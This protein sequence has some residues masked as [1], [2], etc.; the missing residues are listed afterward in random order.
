MSECPSHATKRRCEGETGAAA[1][2]AGMRR[3]RMRW[4][5]TGAACQ[6]HLTGPS[7]EGSSVLQLAR[8]RRRWLVAT[9][10][11]VAAVGSFLAWG[12]IGLG[13]GPI[14][15]PTAESGTYSW[16]ESRTEP[17]VYVLP[18]GNHGQGAAI[19]DT[20]VVTGRQG[21]APPVLLRAFAGRMSGY[22]C[23]AL[24]PFSGPRPVWAGCVQPRLDRVRGAAI[25]PGTYLF[26]GRIH[27]HEPALVLELAGPDPGKCWDMTSVVIHYHVG[28]RRYAG[29][30]PQANVITCGVGAKAPELN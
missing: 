3:A 6:T 22:A 13:N 21:F 26:R 5:P 9:V 8:R 23:T 12:P 17:A 19:I 14:W 27:K 16:N 10:V 29:T 15:V 30:F 7:E 4:C 20:V 11:A 1:G 28:I 25:P 2:R 18:I 24:G